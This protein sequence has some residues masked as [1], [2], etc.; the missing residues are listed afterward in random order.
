MRGWLAGLGA[1]TL[2]IA[3]RSPWENAY[4]E[5]FNSRLRDELLDREVFETLKEAKVIIE[6][7]RLESNHRRP[8][9]SLGYRTPAGFAVA[10]SKP[11]VASLPR[12]TPSRSRTPPSHNP[13]TR[14]RG[15]VTHATAHNRSGALFGT[16][17]DCDGL[18]NVVWSLLPCGLPGSRISL[19]PRV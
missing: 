11:G 3:P 18:L 2:Y 16:P 7:H 5:T 10:R 14:I 15:Q 9:S 19:A 4:S 13:W 12:P 6:D 17:R 8:H 1:K